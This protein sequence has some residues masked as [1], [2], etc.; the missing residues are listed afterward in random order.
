MFKDLNSLL[1]VVCRLLLVYVWSN[2]CVML[3]RIMYDKNRIVADHIRSICKFRLAKMCVVTAG[4]FDI[5]YCHREV[6]MTN[7]YCLNDFKWGKKW[8]LSA[9]N[10]MCDLSSSCISFNFC[11]ALDSPALLLHVIA[12]DSFITPIV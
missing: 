1:Y 3:L 12:F 6:K 4:T 11:F 5:L 9:F 7:D 10:P 8:Y 2:A